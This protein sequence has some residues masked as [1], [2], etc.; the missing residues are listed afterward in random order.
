MQGLQALRPQWNQLCQGHPLLCWEWL[1]TWWK[2]F[3]N[4]RDELFVLTVTDQTG[5]LIGIAPWFA[6]FSVGRGRVIH[7]LGCDRVFSDYQTVLHEK[8]YERS[9]AAALTSWLMHHAEG[10]ASI[11]LAGVATTDSIIR[12]FTNQL[13][14]ADHVVQQEQLQSC[15][16]IE[17]PQTWDEYLQRL[18]KTRRER[19]RQLVRNYFDTNR[20]VI[21]TA[22]SPQMLQAGLNTLTTLH[23]KRWNSLGQTGCFASMEFH[24]FLS[25]VSQEFFN[26]G[27]LRLQWV[28]LDG[29][30][31]AAEMDFKD[32]HTLYMYQSGMDPEFSRHRP[33]WLGTIATL[34]NAID[35]NYRYYDFLRGDEPYKAHWRGQAQPL[36]T[37]RIF[38]NNPRAQISRTLFNLR[39]QAKRYIK[40]LS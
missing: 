2:H 36:S 11:E 14:Q 17:L 23:Q 6:R 4:Q 29:Q 15:W 25:E 18:S 32:D 33:G 34:R 5:R 7:F 38:A 3:R 13:Q 12:H 30:P 39:S 22:D 19:A 26:I 31:V 28:E 35:Q 10:Y 37:V 1:I 8:G 21:H 20:A 9:V 16:R 40:S 27:K 24:A